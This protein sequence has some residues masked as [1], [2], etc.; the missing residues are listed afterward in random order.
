MYKVLKL[1]EI[2]PVIDSVFPAAT[3]D[4]SKEQ[5][6]PDAILLRSF[7]MHEY[8]LAD[9]LL[10]VARC[11]AGTNNIPI[12]KCTE[13]GIVVFNT[14]GANANAVKELVL[15]GLLLGSRKIVAGIEWAASL[16]GNGDAVAKM[17]EKGKGQFV[18]PEIMGKK[19]AVIGLGAIG[20]KI[21]NA[22]VALGMEVLGYDPYLSIDAAWSLDRAV[23]KVTDFAELLKEAD[24]V[25]LHIPLTATNK[26]M[27]NN[28]TFAK[29]KNGAVLLNFSRGELVANDDV[30]AAVASGKIS[31][32]VTD[33]PCEDLLGIENV[34]C[35]PHLGASTPEAEDNCAYM[36][37]QQTVDYLENGNIR[38]S[39]NYPAADM[40][41]SGKC[42]VAI[43]HRNVKDM[44]SQITALVSSEGFNIENFVSKSRGD[45]AYSMLDLDA[46]AGDRL[47]QDL[48]KIEGIL[49]VRIL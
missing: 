48:A 44:I 10:A 17:V 22:A 40:P 19:L 16:K 26:Y 7:A 3:Y 45:F 47:A 46:K 37:A 33:F 27:F 4:V 2:S 14:P 39:V 32:Y 29:M 1:N 42:R 36:A 24:Y 8:P 18:G 11:G 15:A 25:T 12:D 5:S 41:R 30:K 20:A 6:A 28:E 21:A 49:R 31:R 13:K 9:S 43:H 35:I 23:K 34:I 38:N